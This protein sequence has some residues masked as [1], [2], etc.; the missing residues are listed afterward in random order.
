LLRRMCRASLAL[1]FFL[2]AAQVTVSPAWAQSA[3]EVLAR[4][5]DIQSKEGPRAALAEIQRS[6]AI[7]REKHDRHGEAVALGVLGYCY[8]D[9]ADYAQA[10]T[11]L[12]QALALKRE[13]GDRAEECKT[14]NNLG[15]VYWDTADYAKA[16][17]TYNQ[18]L[19]IARE[20]HERRFEGAILNNLGLIS[21][22]QGSYQQALELFQ[23][24]LEAQRAIHFDEGVSNTLGN[25]GGVYLD[26]GR[27]PEALP[28]YQ[29]AL[30]IDER[31]QLKPNAMKDLGN[32]ALTYL[33]LGRPDEAL[34]TYDRALGLARETG[35]KKEEADWHKGKGSTLLRLGKYDAAREEFQQAL[36]VDESAGL[37]RELVETLSGD[38]TLHLELGDTVSAEK[39]F[40]RAI[41]L[42]RK[43]GH[44]R[45]VTQNLIALGDLEWHAGRLDQAAALYEEAFTRAREAADQAAMEESLLQLATALRDQGRFEEALSKAQQALEIARANGATL[46]EAQARYALG[47]VT[48]R[49]GQPQEAL[50][51]YEAGEAIAQAAGDT[52]LGW[53][54]AYGKGQALEALGRNDEAIAAY[55]HAVEIIESVRSQLREERFRAGYLE[56]KYQVYV[57]LVHLLL[58]MGKTGEAFQFSEKLRALSYLELLNRSGHAAG[59]KP[60]EALRAQIRQLQHALE[61]ENAKPGT[62]RKEAV[63]EALSSELTEAE[64]KYQA[65]LDD[66]RAA[67]P[68]GGQSQALAVP[69]ADEV[70]QQLPADAAL[71]EYL[72]GQESLGLFVLSGG[73]LHATTVPLRA[74]DLRAKIELFRDLVQEN[75]GRDWV[76]PA[77]SLERLLIAPAEQAGWLEGVTRLYLVPNATLYYLPFAALPRQEGKTLR[78]LIQ[79]YELV[80]LPSASALIFGAGSTDPSGK[81]LALAPARSRLRFAEQE[82]RSVRAFFPA[83]S[84]LLLGREATKKA[85]EREADQFEIIHLAT[86]G[87]FDKINP[88]FSGVQLEP[89]AKDNGRLE[90]YEILRLR[91]HARLVTLSACETALGSGYFSEF[92]P[93]DDFI[94][95]PRAFLSAG[96]Q[97]VLASLWE[98]NDRS[99]MLLMGRFYKNL[100]RLPEVAALRQAQL[101]MLQE[102][103]RYSHPFFWAPFILVGA[104][105]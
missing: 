100:Q 10:L 17:D 60:E 42:A 92:P 49:K 62:E 98:V 78:F 29:Q 71:I 66:L 2:T 65:L 102:G 97:Q 73:S 105:K 16:V 40:R 25:I 51:H 56:D 84:L 20:I 50:P 81:L 55:R 58:K 26:L 19:K 9:L 61:D 1:A 39:D 27:Y 53:Q 44:P 3:D 67:A 76:K 87:F 89:E 18:A 30:E 93:G 23:Q 79:R 99:T 74:S 48:R 11:Y 8:Y 37:Q 94:G 47:E 90:V 38:G 52:E 4:A 96:S 72:V 101:D 43:I 41:E 5:R 57:A 95:L 69:S 64:R 7:Y 36:Q 83:N 63:A 68:S 91:L 22:Q 21:S 82:A 77:E 13:L 32:L 54:L 86:H 12:Q 45:G 70:A 80:Y 46:V 6:L 88:M 35:Q 24:A 15:L 75:K 85:F 33:G 14:L 34:K 59:G 28:S 104:K 103:G 31:S